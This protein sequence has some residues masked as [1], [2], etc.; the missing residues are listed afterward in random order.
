[1][2]LPFRLPFQFSDF[3]WRDLTAASTYK[4]VGETKSEQS[5]TKE[6]REENRDRE[7]LHGCVQ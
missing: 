1:M 4:G 5:E 7:K 2:A 3:C 6:Q